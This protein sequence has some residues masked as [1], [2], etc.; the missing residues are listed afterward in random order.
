[1]IGRH[2]SRLAVAGD[3]GAADKI[4]DPRTGAEIEDQTAPRTL[5]VRVLA[6]AGATQNRRHRGDRRH[7]LRQLR[8]H[9]H[10]LAIA[11]Q[12]L[13]GSVTSAIMRS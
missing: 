4:H 6:A 12:P 8:G 10:S 7:R 3:V 2:D 5:V 1:V 13:L 9:E 11:R